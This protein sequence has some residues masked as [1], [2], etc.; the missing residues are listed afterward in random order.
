MAV[1]RCVLRDDDCL[2]PGKGFYFSGHAPIH[3]TYTLEEWGVVGPFCV[4]PRWPLYVILSFLFDETLTSSSILWDD[5]LQE[6]EVGTLRRRKDE[7]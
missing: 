5:D 6:W 4:L 2:E 7:M 1:R 3:V